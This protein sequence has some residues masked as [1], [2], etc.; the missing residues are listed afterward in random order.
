MNLDSIVE[1]QA[2]G[3]EG[4]VVVVLGTRMLSSSFEGW[5]TACGGIGRK[6]EAVGER[7]DDGGAPVGVGVVGGRGGKGR[8][9][10]AVDERGDCI[11]PEFRASRRRNSGVCW[12]A[13]LIVDVH[14]GA[15]SVTVEQ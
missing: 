13:G 6:D 11:V 5:S 3:G 14:D 15:R 10:E 9:G 8:K 7:G 4:G 2:G 1:N 12:N